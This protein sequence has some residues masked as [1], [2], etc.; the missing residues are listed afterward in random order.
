MT[1]VRVSTLIEKLELKN[2]TEMIDTSQIIVTRSDINRPALQLTGYY[3]HFEKDRVQIIGNVEEEYLHQL[4]IEKRKECYDK[5]FSFHIPCLIMCRGYYPDKA[6]YD[7]AVKYGVPLLMTDKTTSDI[8]AETIRWLKV[9]LAPMITIHGVLVDVFGEGVLITGESGIGKSEVALELIRRGH[10]LVSDDVVEIRKVSNDELIGSAP[11]IT[12]HFIELRGIGI[13]DAKMLFGVESVK[14]SQSIHMVIQLED[15]NREKE[16]DRIGLDEN[17]IEYLG[18][19]VSCYSIP[20]RPGRNV[21][22][23]VESAAINYR[24][25]LMGYNAAQ[26]LYNRVQNNLTKGSVDII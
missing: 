18:N 15:W 19:K 17:Y 2:L 9:Q 4:P 5:L 12:R 24:Q 8:M 10:R 23:I 20:V 26:E 21:A 25:K 22:I 3:A 14:D 16:Y 11:D 1:G 13:I 6:M 7:S